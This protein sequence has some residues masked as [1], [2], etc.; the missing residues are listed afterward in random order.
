MS[1]SIR[2]S[3]QKL[4]ALALE[5]FVAAA[6]DSDIPSLRGQGI[7]NRLP[8]SGNVYFQFGDLRIEQPGATVVIEVESS[9]GVTNLAKYWESI[10]SQRLNKPIRLLHLFR[11]TSENDYLAHM[12][13]WRFLA[14]RMKEALGNMFDGVCM[15]YRQGSP[16]S[17]EPVVS[18]FKRWLREKATP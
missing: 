16:D 6:N 12:V 8:I 17:L 7:K 14:L 5:P 1:S 10:A 2:I 3:R 18:L 13:V 9:V 15:T 11:Q 4:E